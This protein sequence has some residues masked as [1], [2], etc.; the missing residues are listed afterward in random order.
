MSKLKR[1]RN[2]PSPKVHNAMIACEEYDHRAFKKLKRIQREYDEKW[3]E[4]PKKNPDT[5]SWKRHRK[6]QYRRLAHFDLY[7]P[8]D[9]T[10][11]HTATVL[12]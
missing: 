9:E 10:W 12:A 2:N 8:E 5:K 1:Y 7:V 3:W 4:G 11:H 6:T